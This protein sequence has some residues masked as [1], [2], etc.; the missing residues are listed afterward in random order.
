MI[1]EGEESA[2]MLR[3]FSIV[4]KNW[5]LIIPRGALQLMPHALHFSCPFELSLSLRTKHVLFDLSE[6]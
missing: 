2:A 1:D 6:G 3:R 5:T 4:Q